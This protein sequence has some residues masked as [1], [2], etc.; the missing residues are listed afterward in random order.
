MDYQNDVPKYRKKAKPK[1]NPRAK[2]KHRYE[3]CIFETNWFSHYEQAHG[4]VADLVRAPGTYCSICGKI[5][6]HMMPW[7][8]FNKENVEVDSLPVFWCEDG[9]CQKYINLE[10][11]NERSKEN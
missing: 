6:I 9:P 10:E 7:A 3:K 8:H 11:V 4:M 1:P 2:H 5:G